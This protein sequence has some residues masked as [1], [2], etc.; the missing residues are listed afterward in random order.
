VDRQGLLG[1]AGLLTQAG[2]PEAADAVLRALHETGLHRRQ[3][4]AGTTP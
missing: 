2:H 4:A 1:P 3:P